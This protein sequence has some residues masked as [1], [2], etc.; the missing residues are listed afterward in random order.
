MRV[1]QAHQR[2]VK[3]ENGFTLIELIISLLILSVLAASTMPVARHV[4]RRQ[5]EQ[6]LKKTLRE[7]RHAIDAYHAVCIGQPGFSQFAEKKDTTCYPPNLKR[8]EK[9]EKLA[10][11]QGETVRFLLRV[12]PN[13]I[14]GVDGEA[15]EDAWDFRSVNNEPG[16]SWDG[17]SVFDIRCKSDERAI[18]GTYYR[19]W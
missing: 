11:V 14:T 18:D 6:E 2:K 5:R 19:D 4:M 1:K 9:G 17:K 16:D 12:P 13:P 15:E 8:L 10:T 7:I 3:G